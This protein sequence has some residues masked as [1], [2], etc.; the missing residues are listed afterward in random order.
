MTPA[1]NLLILTAS[2]VDAVVARLD[3]EELVDLTK[4]VF[5]SIPSDAEKPVCPPRLTIPAPEHTALVMPA[6][7]P[8]TSKVGG[9]AIKIVSV[10]QKIGLPA[11]TILLDESGRVE[12]IVNARKLTALRN[13]AAS[14]LSTRLLFQRDPKRVIAFGAGE[15]I[16][17]HLSL[18]CRAYKSIEGCTIVGRS[19]STRLPALIVSLSTKF[20]GVDF[21]SL[22]QDI[23]TEEVLADA[24]IIICA[25]PSTTPLFEDLPASTRSLRKHVIL[26]G[27]YTPSMHEIPGPLA[28][29]ATTVCVDDVEACLKEAGELIEAGF[30][31]EEVVD[32]GQLLGRSSKTDKTEKGFTLFKSVGTGLQDVAIAR[33]VLNKAKEISIG[34]SVPQYD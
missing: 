9:T 11:S 32:L 21:Q 23:P 5:G 14:L 24:D 18:F 6:R 30:R 22:S 31:K 4:A 25:T 29:R 33:S 8:A 20:P 17:A 2:D 1:T 34:T 27:S 15:Q 16:H 10:T 12:A 26:I 3:V 19:N 13:A 7:L 28:R